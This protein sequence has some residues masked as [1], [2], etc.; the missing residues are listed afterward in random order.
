MK[1][2][3]VPQE[4]RGLG[5]G[6]ALCDQVISAARAEDYHSMRLDTGKRQTEAMRLYEHAGFRRIAPYYPVP[7]DFKDYLI[8]YELV[9]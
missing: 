7:Y 9:L 1:R 3:F 4:F 2:M 5:V 8:F 6:R